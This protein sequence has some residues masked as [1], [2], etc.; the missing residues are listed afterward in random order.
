MKN[1]SQQASFVYVLSNHRYQYSVEENYFTFLFSYHNSGKQEARII[2]NFKPPSISQ[3]FRRFFFVC[4][5]FNE[6]WSA[7][8]NFNSKHWSFVN[9]PLMRCITLLQIYLMK[10]ADMDKNDSSQLHYKITSCFWKQIL[11]FHWEW[12]FGGVWNC[13]EG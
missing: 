6:N 4:F 3:Y 1:V 8:D 13:L 10:E 9:L 12:S 11:W 2:L 5:F 7:K